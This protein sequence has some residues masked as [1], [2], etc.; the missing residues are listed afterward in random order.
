MARLDKDDAKPNE[1]ADPFEDVQPER[2]GTGVQLVLD[3][4]GY[5]GPIDALLQ[6]AR[7]QKVDLA[8]ISILALADQYLAFVVHARKI[9]HSKTFKS[10]PS[11]SPNIGSTTIAPITIK[12][13]NRSSRARGIA[14]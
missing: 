14:S 10:I 13:P 9:S 5:E 6:L 11:R 8:T 2:Q 3:L 4:E 12:S 1:D 7:D